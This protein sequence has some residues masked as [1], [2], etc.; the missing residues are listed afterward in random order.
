VVDRIPRCRAENCTV[1]FHVPGATGKS[2]QV[3][4]AVDNLTLSV[5][6]GETVGLVGESGCGKT[7][8]G[9][10]ITR[11]QP[12]DSGRVL[13]D[14]SDITLLTGKTL[15]QQRRRIQMIFQNPFASLDP[16]MTVYN[17]ISEVLPKPDRKDREGREDLVAGYLEQVSLDPTMMRKFPHEFSG[18]QRQRIA[19]AR[20][21]AV[22]PSLIIADE[23]VSSLDVSVAAQILNLLHD[24]RD[25]LHLTIILIS[26][27]LAIV[28]YM[29]HKVA[30]MYHGRIV[31]LGSPS[32]LYARPC[33]PY[34]ATLL[35]VVPSIPE[36]FPA[37]P[38]FKKVSPKG[39]GKDSPDGCV[40]AARCGFARDECLRSIPELLPC[41]QD[42]DHLCACFR[43]GEW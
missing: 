18:G 43:A 29:A 6:P 7:T 27:D 32:V 21:L 1:S 35:E 16:R 11:F 38:F 41:S 12:L 22:Q 30:V 36:K 33:H 39:D 9:R 37:E 34:T 31:E 14:G 42:E 8:L 23:P 10:A 19:I 28:R 3:L 24:V 17:I 4:H 2:A 20:A 5:F 15:R 26:H 40:F 13:I 25:Q